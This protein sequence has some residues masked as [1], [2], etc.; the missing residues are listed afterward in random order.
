MLRAAD[1]EWNPPHAAHTGSGEFSA[2]C[3]HDGKATSFVIA[4]RG[5]FDSSAASSS[6]AETR[7][8]NNTGTLTAKGPGIAL[9]FH[10][11]HTAPDKLS[12]TTAPAEPRNLGKPAPPP[13][14]FGQREF[15][16]ANGR[17]FLLTDS[18][19]VRQFDL[20]TPPVTDPASA[21][22]L[23][24]LIDAIPPQE[25]QGLATPQPE[26]ERAQSLFSKWQDRARTDGKIPGALIG[27]V[28]EQVE[29]FIK[30]YP[31]DE[32]AP[33]LAALRGRFDVSRD[34]EPAEVAALLDEVAAISTAPVGWA[35]LPMEFNEFR[36]V[37]PGAP[38]PADLAD[39]AWGEPAENGL[40]A[41]WI[42]EP[43]AERY[44]LGTVLKARVAF[45]NAGDEPVVFR[46]ETWH[47]SDEHIARDADGA[48]IKISGTF[49]TGI[50]PLAVYRLL[51]GEYCEVGGHGIAIG[52]GDYKEE[53]SLGQVGAIIE[54]RAGDEVTLTHTV[55]AAQGIRFSR[56]GDPDDPAELWAKQVAERVA[57]DAPLPRSAADRELLIRRVMRDLFGTPPTPEEVAAF[58]DD[59]APEALDRLVDRLLEKPR[60]EPWTGKLPTGE[61]KFRVTAADPNAAKAPRVA[62]SPGRY[63]LGDGV[64]LQVTQTTSGGQRTNKATIQFLSPDPKV[65][66]PH[67]PY[68]I[69]FYKDDEEGAVYALAWERGEGILWVT[70]IGE[71]SDIP[72]WIAPGGSKPGPQKV[73]VRAFDFSDPA[74]VKVTHVSGSENEGGWS[75]GKI[76]PEKFHQPVLDALGERGKRLRDFLS[77]PKPMTEPEPDPGAA[78]P[79]ASAPVPKIDWSEFP[80]YHEI[81][82]KPFDP[83]LLAKLASAPERTPS[84]RRE[85]ACLLLMAAVEKDPQFRHVVNDESLKESTD[86]SHSLAL[87]LAA[88]DFSVN[89]SVRAR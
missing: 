47:Q 8:W 4:Y 48:A 3:V 64:H 54:A 26:H 49:Y 87:S 25:E 27:H 43:K 9:S 7:T 69:G 55:D 61:S 85:L 84:E 41:A 22:K 65:A 36:Q 33:K 88:Y 45:H 86:E 70:E 38:L 2:F 78:A 28:G 14:E 73:I 50:T 19:L 32:A 24:A 1:E 58:T 77:Q 68:E 29:Q 15:D 37:K 16:L 56:P 18:G 31:D 60:V 51:P 63:V 40:R 39:A 74:A 42:L 62:T 72:I 30:Q 6:N 44:P 79:P 89:G 13:R 66:S 53:F 34:W 11:D 71:G 21:K 23:A 57:Q 82:S 12:L 17:V 83:A 59:A 75:W 67:E 35:D 76:V 20:P 80:A 46:T 10:R 5:D 81:L 52:A